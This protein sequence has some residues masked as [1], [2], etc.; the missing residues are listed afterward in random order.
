MVLLAA[1]VGVLTGAGVALLDTVV[2][3]IEERVVDLPLAIVALAPAVGLGLTAALL[4]WVGRRRESRRPP[5]S[6]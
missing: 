6:T 3:G 2:L 4:R 5:T 1:I